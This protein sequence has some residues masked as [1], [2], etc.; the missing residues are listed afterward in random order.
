MVAAD[1]AVAYTRFFSQTYVEVETAAR[2]AKRGLWQGQF[3]MPWDVRAR[4]KMEREEGQSV[5]NLAP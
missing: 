5:T 2:A 3:E 1:L 4:Q